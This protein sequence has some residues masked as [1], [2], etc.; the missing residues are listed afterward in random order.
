MRLG[1]RQIEVPD[2][3]LRAGWDAPENRQ[4]PRDVIAMVSL[5]PSE[6]QGRT[7]LKFQRTFDD[8]DE[9]SV[10]V[11]ELS[12]GDTF[13]LIRHDNLPVVGTYVAANTSPPDEDRFLAQI[14]QE[15]GIDAREITWRR[16]HALAEEDRRLGSGE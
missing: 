1:V 4:L 15:L 13:A 8:L 3:G 11:G 5:S 14:K 7:N 12:S 9:F 16:A 10:A 6:L 2:S